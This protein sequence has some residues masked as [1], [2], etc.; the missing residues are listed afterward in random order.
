MRLCGNPLM[1][2]GLNSVEISRGTMR[3]F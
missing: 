2:V 3:R 1:Q